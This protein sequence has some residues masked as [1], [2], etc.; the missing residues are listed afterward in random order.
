MEPLLPLDSRDRCSASRPLLEWDESER[1]PAGVADDVAARRSRVAGRTYA[2]KDT[3]EW[4]MRRSRLDWTIVRPTILTTG[5]RTG[6]YRVL[7]DAGLVLRVHL[8]RRRGGLPRQ[9]DQRSQPYSSDASGDR[10][11]ARAGALPLRLAIAF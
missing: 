8:A 9:A 5:L 6:A 1:L 2:D 3:L 4:I 7:V 11:I 10:L